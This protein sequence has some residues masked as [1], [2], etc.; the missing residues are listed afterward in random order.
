[1]AVLS[2]LD[3]LRPADQRSH[4]G[5]FVQQVLDGDAG[6]VVVR[7]ADGMLH[8]LTRGPEGILVP[9][10]MI[11]VTLAVTKPERFRLTWLARQYE[12]APALRAG[13]IAMIVTAILGALV[14]DS[15]VQVPAVCLGVAV[16]WVL[17]A[18]AR[19]GVTSDT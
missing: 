8:S 19:Q 5:R 7:K 15:G 17:A 18:C 2:T 12:H 14:N 10:A 4:L 6:D 3:W 16:P 13:L 11:L 9:I 1:M